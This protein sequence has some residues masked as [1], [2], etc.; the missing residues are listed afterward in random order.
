MKDGAYDTERFEAD[1]YGWQYGAVNNKLTDFRTAFLAECRDIEVYSVNQVSIYRTSHLV[2]SASSRIPEDLRQ[3]V[4]ANALRARFI[5]AD[6][7]PFG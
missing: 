4:P 5:R 3:R 6:E 2:T 1:Y 7:P